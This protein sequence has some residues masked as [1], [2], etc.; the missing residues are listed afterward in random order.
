MDEYVLFPLFVRIYGIVISRL[1]A[2]ASC[3]IRD[4][5]TDFCNGTSA[6]TVCS[7]QETAEQRVRF[8]LLRLGPR[9]AAGFSP[10]IVSHVF[11]GYFVA[12]PFYR[13]WLHIAIFTYNIN[14]PLRTLP[15]Y[16]VCWRWLILNDDPTTSDDPKNSSCKCN[17][18]HVT[19]S[20][21]PVSA[22]HV[23][24]VRYSS[25]LEIILY[26]PIV[27]AP[28][29]TVA[30]TLASTG[31]EADGIVEGFVRS[32]ELHGLKF[33][34]LIGDVDSSVSKRLMEL[35][36]YGFNKLV[37]KNRMSKPHFKELQYK[38]ISADK[39]MAIRKAIL[40]RRELDASDEYK[41][42]GLQ[43]NIL[44]SPYYIFGQYKNCD[45]YFCKT[46]KNIENHVPAIE[47]CGLMLEI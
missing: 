34:R 3:F 2:M 13:G 23:D 21:R 39:I 41:I 11:T 22:N 15:V 20:F 44:N 31:M 32:V 28:K 33:N 27:H 1:V 8:D 4:I 5:M 19:K 12:D 25:R 14:Y 43:K 9:V 47:K 45:A 42:K 24:V 36:P 7:T 17:M 38:I 10:V 40:Y 26:A 6:F 35:V 30:I 46:H 29:S 16:A 18:H 37:K